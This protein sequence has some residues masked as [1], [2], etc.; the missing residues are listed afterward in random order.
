MSRLERIADKKEKGCVYISLVGT[1]TVS[2]EDKVIFVDGFSVLVFDAFDGH[3]A[4]EILVQLESKLLI[5][6]IVNDSGR[7]ENTI[8]LYL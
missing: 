5:M 2:S 6:G 7:T 3:I 1:S 4:V 8:F